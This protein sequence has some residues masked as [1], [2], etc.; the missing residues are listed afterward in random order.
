MKL[1]TVPIPAS[2]LPASEGGMTVLDPATLRERTRGVHS[3]HRD[4]VRQDRWLRELID[5]KRQSARTP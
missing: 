2:G 4:G 1:D 5:T 3:F